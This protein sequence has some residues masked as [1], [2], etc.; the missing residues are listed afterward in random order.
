VAD[1]ES[2]VDKF[3]A[4]L[5]RAEERIKEKTAKSAPVTRQQS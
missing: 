3:K 5:K 4:A 2:T 1:P